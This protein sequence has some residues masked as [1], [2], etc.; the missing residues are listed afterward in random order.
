MPPLRPP[1]VRMGSA[2][3]PL[4]HPLHQLQRRARDLLFDR[5]DRHIFRAGDLGEGKIVE[6]AL[7]QDAPGAFGQLVETP[8]GM[9]KS[10]EE[11]RVGKECVSTCRAWWSQAR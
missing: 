11:R 5:R 4:L 3:S 6:P 2:R 1:S 10:S 7:Q 8:R 9:G